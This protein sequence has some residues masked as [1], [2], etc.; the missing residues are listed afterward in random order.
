MVMSIQVARAL[1]LLVLVSGA[2]LGSVGCSGGEDSGACVHTFKSDGW[3]Y[4][5][6]DWDKS[7]CGT[8]GASDSKTSAFHGGDSC[9]D[10]GFTYYC[11]S[12]YTY[13]RNSSRCD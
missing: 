6:Q 8:I 9:E 7:E 12:T 1:S 5:N 13:H 3:Q 2:L 4:C 11:G 10:L